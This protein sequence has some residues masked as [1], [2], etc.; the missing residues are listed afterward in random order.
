MAAAGAACAPT[1]A[2]AGAPTVAAVDESVTVLGAALVLST[3]HC[4]IHYRSRHGEFLE[5]FSQEAME[6]GRVRVVDGR[7]VVTNEGRVPDGIIPL[8]KWVR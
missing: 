3:L 8:S 2:A 7:L 6:E 1:V 5:R 4:E